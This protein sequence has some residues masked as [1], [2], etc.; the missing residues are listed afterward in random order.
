MLKEFKDFIKKGDVVTIAV[1]L[2]IALFFK[3]I[4]D[5]VVTGVITPIVAAIAGESDFAAI[6]FKVGEARISI[7][8]VIEAA[9]NFVLVAFILY[10]IL[11]A[12]NKMKAADG[13]AGPTEVELLTEIRDQL[14]AR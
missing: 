4:I 6:G 13:P 14:K 1:G 11:K 3:A 10:V 2:V 9:I 7:G 12:Y 8:L 5:A